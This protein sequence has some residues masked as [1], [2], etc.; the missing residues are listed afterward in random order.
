MKLIYSS[1]ERGQALILIALAA[2]GLF[3]IAGL[4]IDGSVKYS[5]RRHA[6]NAADTAALAGALSLANNKT[7][8][9]SGTVQQWQYD[10]L[11]RAEGNGYNRDLVTNQVWV[12]RCSDDRNN[13]GSLRYETPVETCGPYEGKPE[14]I[15]VV[16]TTNVN[17][18]FARVLGINQTH[19]TV[20]TIAHAQQSYKGQLYGGGSMIAL[21]Q[22]ECKAIWFSGSAA[23]AIEGGGVHSNSKEDCG[24]TLQG[25]KGFEIAMDSSINMVADAYTLNGKVDLKDI[26]GG[27][28]GAANQYEYPPPENLL[29]KITCGS[30]SATQSG[31][32]MTPGN[33]S[34]T[35]PPSG[36]STLNP[37]TYCVNGK[38]KLNSK[39]KLSGSGVTIYMQSGEIDWNGGAE[40][41]LSA[42]TSGDLAGLLM[43]APMNN[44]STMR[45][46]GNASTDLTGTIF[47]PAAPLIYNGTGNLQPSHVQ[48]IAYTIEITGSNATNI[49]YQDSDN[50]DENLPAQL[51]I[52][53]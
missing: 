42:P 53:Q 2:I 1:T 51:G 13:P 16:I 34:G 48:I 47:M 44:T 38:F 41:H 37:G 19:N 28:H 50:W 3:A 49:L 27:I 15:Q 11:L 26:D 32:S 25:A 9:V 36:V 21:A 33:W 23:V 43:Y 6:Q 14:Y 39:D 40:I 29:P 52:M 8:V 18:Y 5:D 4:A 45:F 31:T 35:F 20:H 46:N 12:Y 22:A 7:N 24:V 30:A 10:A 17:T